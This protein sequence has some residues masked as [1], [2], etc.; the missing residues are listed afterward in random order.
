MATMIAMTKKMSLN[1]VIILQLATLLHSSA[2]ITD[3]FLI[4]GDV[5]MLMI[6]EI[7][8]MKLTVVSF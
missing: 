6:V 5:T 4:D 1:L 2:I 8:L 3:V 7:I